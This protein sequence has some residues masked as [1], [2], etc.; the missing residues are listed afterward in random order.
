MKHKKLR[1]ELILFAAIVFTIA[2]ICHLA[3]AILQLPITVGD[4]NFPMWISYLAIVV[5]FVLGV[6]YWKEAIRK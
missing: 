2:F 1:A 3:R 4:W 6:F 5:T